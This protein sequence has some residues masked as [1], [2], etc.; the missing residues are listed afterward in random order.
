MKRIVYLIRQAEGGMIKHLVGLLSYLDREKYEP[1]T[2]APPEN[3]LLSSLD[4][5]GVTLYQLGISDRPDLYKDVRTAFRLRKVFNKARPDLLHVH[6][7]KAALIA[8]LARAFQKDKVPMVISVHNYPSYHRSNVISR[9]AGSIAL[10]FI[11]RKACKVIAVSDA[12]KRDLIKVDHLQESRIVTIHNGIDTGVI[13]KNGDAEADTLREAL[14]IMDGDIVIGTA[15]RL[16]EGKGHVVLIDAAVKLL[17]DHP[18]VKVVIAGDGPERKCLEDRISTL[19]LKKSVIL[20]GFMDDLDPFF[21]LVD[22]FVLPSFSEA[23]G[24]VLLEA[25]N[26]GRPV[27]ASDA[28]GIPEIVRDGETGLLF[29]AGDVD[30]LAA[31]LERLLGDEGLGSKLIRNA[32]RMVKEEFSLEKMTRE[33]E[34]VYDDCL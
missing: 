28:G 4:S 12:V 7:H 8:V 21:R 18:Q 2:I 6:G 23:F 33:T 22:A 16:I 14:G 34:K 29:H 26:A 13:E 32:R 17:R 31:A 5:L 19:K 3:N 30:Q 24:I 20:P 1:Y 15:G 9:I 11:V 25:M 10:R 27:V